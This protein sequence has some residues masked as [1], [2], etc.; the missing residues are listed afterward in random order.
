MQPT[1]LISQLAAQII[2]HIRTQDA[3]P[4]ARLVER[5]LA[6]HFRVSRSPIRKALQ[7]LE[8]SGYLRVIEPGGGYAVLKTG[9]DLAAMPRPDLTDEDEAAYLRIAEDRLGGRFPS[10][11]TESRLARDYGLTRAQLVRVLRRIS[12]EGWVERLPGH[13][14]AFLPVL[15]SMQAYRDSYRFRLVIEPAAILEPTFVLNR[16]LVQERR[17]EQQNLID[18]AIRDVSNAML[19]ELNSR[20]HETII[21]CSHNPFFIDG[22]KRIDRLLRLME[23]DRSLDRAY[24]ARRVREHI[25][26]ADL[27][28]A[29]EREEAA[30][31]MT[32]HLST[33]SV[34]KA[35]LRPM[36]GR[37]PGRTEAPAT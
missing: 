22:L 10:K 19:F 35:V 24:S 26:I 8:Q 3:A 34:D 23:Y 25:Q 14:W 12:S 27:L 2:D 1:P 15:N 31:A 11:I 13:G 21:E 17:D 20:L 7:L 5:A 6:E 32:R 37:R 29:G 9:A 36:P 28:L 33:I 18:G 30:L 16:A 4:G